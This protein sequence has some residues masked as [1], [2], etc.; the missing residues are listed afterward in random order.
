ME[1]AYLLWNAVI[2]L[3]HVFPILIVKPCH[4]LP[5]VVRRVARA[6]LPHYRWNPRGS[7]LH[8]SQKTCFPGVR[9]FKKPVSWI[10]NII[11]VRGTHSLSV[12]R[13]CSCK[14]LMGINTHLSPASRRAESE[15]QTGS[16][17]SRPAIRTAE[18]DN[19]LDSFDSRIFKRDITPVISHIVYIVLLPKD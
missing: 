12:T 8:D 10:H 17:R 9:I 18:P 2:G 7:Y 11:I 14:A 5:H 15:K 1:R 16:T 3:S 6:S 19:E 13:A 4:V